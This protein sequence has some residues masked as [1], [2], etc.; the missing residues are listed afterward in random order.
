MNVNNNIS[1]GINNINNN[2]Q[3]QNSNNSAS[4]KRREKGRLIMQE[5][6]VKSGQNLLTNPN[7]QIAITNVIN[8]NRKLN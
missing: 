1:G 2:G 6:I 8:P 4:L 7:A 5:W 3:N